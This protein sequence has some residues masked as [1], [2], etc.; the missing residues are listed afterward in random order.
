MPALIKCEVIQARDLPEM[1]RN[2]QGD[3]YTDAYVDIRFGSES[4]R[5]KV[6]HKTLS[7]EWNETFRFEVAENEKLQLEPMDVLEL[8]KVQVY[9]Q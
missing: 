2:I 3:L 4:Q 7:P 5:T 8:M 6:K 9:Q 1:D